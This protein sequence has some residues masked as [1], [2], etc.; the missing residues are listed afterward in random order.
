[1]RNLVALGLATAF[2]MG[3]GA[4]CKASFETE[5]YETNKG[6]FQHVTFGRWHRKNL[7]K[8][9]MTHADLQ[10]LLRNED[11]DIILTGSK[12][13]RPFDSTAW[14]GGDKRTSRRVLIK[15]L[16]Q[17]QKVIGMEREQIHGMLGEPEPAT[18][19]PKDKSAKDVEWYRVDVPYNSC[20]ISHAHYETVNFLELSFSSKGRVNGFRAAVRKSGHC[21]PGQGNPFLAGKNTR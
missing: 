5:T 21:Q 12:N 1:M 19:V 15:D 7:S 2:A 11:P 6:F 8:K 10:E 13:N 9:L 3:S 17:S 20:V 4:L 14:K 18:H 16:L